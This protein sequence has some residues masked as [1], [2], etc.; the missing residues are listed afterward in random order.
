[1][2][3]S[4]KAVSES[5]EQKENGSP[6]EIQLLQGKISRL[7]NELN[8]TKNLIQSLLANQQTEDHNDKTTNKHPE[9]RWEKHEK[10]DVFSYNKEGPE[11]RK[12]RKCQLSYTKNSAARDLEDCEEKEEHLRH[13]ELRTCQEKKQCRKK[14]VPKTL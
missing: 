4:I 1:M 7:E 3:M 9:T 14:K 11:E 13:T 2:Q 6:R 10:I 12:A 5:I 8:L